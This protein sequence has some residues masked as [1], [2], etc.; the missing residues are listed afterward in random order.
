MRRRGTEGAVATRFR[1]DVVDLWYAFDYERLH[2]VD[3]LFGDFGARAGLQFDVY[4]NLAVIDLRLKLNPDK[5]RKPNRASERTG[6]HQRHKPTVAQRPANSSGVRLRKRIH[7][8][9][10]WIENTKATLAT[11]QVLRTKNGHDRQ[12][13]E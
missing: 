1:H 6:R 4:T 7:Y 3:H 11:P 12:T 5:L 10:K 8:L 9:F 13:N 2:F